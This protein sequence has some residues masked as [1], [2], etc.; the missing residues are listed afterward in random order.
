[1]TKYNGWSN[2]QTWSVALWLDNDQGTYSH[3]QSVIADLRAED[4]D[5]TAIKEQLSNMLEADLDELPDSL[6]G[7]HRD[8][9]NYSLGMVDW[10]EIAAHMLED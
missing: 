9:L 10:D 2:Q 5:T 3:W 6:Q 1:M 7:P 8:L 4:A